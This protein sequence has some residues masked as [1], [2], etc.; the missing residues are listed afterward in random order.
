MTV[1]LATA[2]QK[3][4]EAVLKGFNGRGRVGC[5][6]PAPGQWCEA[7]VN[8]HV[9]L[10]T[11]T[12]VGPI[13]AAFTLGRVLGACFGISGVVNMGVAGSFNLAKAPLAAPVLV[14][15]EIWP[16]YGLWTDIGINPHGI[17]FPLWAPQE[18]SAQTKQTERAEKAE[19]KPSTDTGTGVVWNNISLTPRESL[20]TM[21]LTPPDCICGTGITVACVSGT[22]ERASQLRQRH[23]ALTENMEGFAMALG[24]VQAGI[25]FVELRTVSNLV[26]S[27]NAEDWR[28]DDALS[29]LG[30]VA[31]SLFL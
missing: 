14:D 21:D 3:E 17:G 19:E 6:L 7:P 2:T 1:L 31:R 20:R 8:E 11:V 13:N 25:D 24:C 16:E 9:C 27:R 18:A 10:L 26:G 30:S 5:Q 22:P 12:G 23:D 29:A 28:L 4:M 15:R